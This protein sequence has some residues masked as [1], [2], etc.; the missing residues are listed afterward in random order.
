MEWHSR[1]RSA[2]LWQENCEDHSVD[3][4]RYA[5]LTVRKRRDVVVCDA[6][7]ELFKDEL[8][9]KYESGVHEGMQ[10][11]MQKG[12]DRLKLL[13]AKLRQDGRE[14]EIMQS[15]MDSDLLQKLYKEYGM[16]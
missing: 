5:I 3:R 7:R 4:V 8:E 15:L 13:Y 6:L 12:E 16:Q 2:G 9:E 14:E 11:G 1:Q 10:K